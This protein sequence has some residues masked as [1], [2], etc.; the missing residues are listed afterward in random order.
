MNS[1]SLRTIPT[2][3]PLRCFTVSFRNYS[4]GVEKLICTHWEINLPLR[5]KWKG[6]KL[7]LECKSQTYKCKP[8]ELTYSNILDTTLVHTVYWF[9]FFTYNSTFYHKRMRIALKN[10]R[11]S[12]TG[13][14][15]CVTHVTQ[16]DK[17]VS[18]DTVISL[19]R[20]TSHHILYT[21]SFCYMEYNSTVK[22]MRNG[23]Q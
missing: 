15:S 8:H 11:L 1:N 22:R 19:M 20:L 10:T 13:A 4:H 18:T 5:S 3:G 7:T 12:A 14:K 17:T 6:R 9:T 23:T 16:T 21:I 2:V